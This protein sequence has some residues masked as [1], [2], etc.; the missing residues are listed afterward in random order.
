M[1]DSVSVFGSTMP[2]KAQDLS[3]AAGST[4]PTV[5]D[6]RFVQRSNVPAYAGPV[7]GLPTPEAVRLKEEELARKAAE[8]AKASEEPAQDAPQE[9]QGEAIAPSEASEAAEEP[10]KAVKGRFTK[11]ANA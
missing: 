2:L 3:M 9:A 1:S 6:E 7:Y 10:K 8:A 5:R 4:V 11:K